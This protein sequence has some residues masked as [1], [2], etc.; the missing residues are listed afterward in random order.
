[1]ARDIKVGAEIKNVI[2]DIEGGRETIGGIYFEGET[3]I[4]VKIKAGEYRATIGQ[5]LIKKT[6]GEL[7]IEIEGEV[8][9]QGSVSE[10]KC[11]YIYRTGRN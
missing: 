3:P 7:E 5:T 8:V 4:S 9:L 2:I 10:T 6:K 1:M 11:G